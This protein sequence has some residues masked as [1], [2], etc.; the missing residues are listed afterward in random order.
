MVFTER[1]NA[2][3]GLPTYRAPWL[4]GFHTT[5]SN[6]AT[7]FMVGVDVLSILKRET[8]GNKK[9]TNTMVKKNEVALKKEG[10]LATSGYDYGEDAG[11]GF[12]GTKGS[13]LSIPFLG[14]LQSN[15]PQVE[16]KDPEGAESGMLYN[17]VTRELFKSD[18][19]VAFLPCHKE[20]AYVEWV[21]RNKGGGF[22]ALH[23]PEGPE[24]ANAIAENGGTRMGKLEIGENELIE[25]HYVYGLVLNAEG[26]QTQGFAVISFTSTKIKPFRDWTTA[27][28]TLRGKPPLFANRAVIRTIKQ[29]NEHGTYYNFRIDPL[30][31][32]WANSLINPSEEANLLEEAKAFQEMVINGMAKAA[33]DTE[34]S[35]G[36]G[37]ASGGA[38]VGDGEDA[39]F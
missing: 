13:D 16:D 38:G 26:N 21:P 8:Y 35:T 23:D 4:R 29:K 34:R 9:E 31:E 24:V 30:L 28:Y 12:E 5:S 20:V 15:S 1:S 36:D 37:G 19:G 6:S 17:T 2:G 33:F 32:T 10:A 22:V 27:M 25:T 18:E 39:P 14:I 7:D 3:S 11:K